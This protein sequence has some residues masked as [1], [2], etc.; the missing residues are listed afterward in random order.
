MLYRLALSMVEGLGPIGGRTLLDAYAGDLRA[1]FTDTSLPEKLKLPENIL[2]QL[3]APSLLGKAAHELEFMEKKRVKGLWFEDADYPWRLR[4]C[5]DAPLMLYV[6]GALPIESAHVLSVVGTRKMTA[7]GRS[8]TQKWVQVLAETVPDLLIV[9]GLALGVDVCA[10]RAALDAGLP[11]A[12]VLGNGLS[13]IYPP[14]HRDIAVEMVEHGALVTE[15]PHD[16][17]IEPFRF[18]QRNRIVAGLSDACLVIESAVKGG[19]MSTAR[20]ARDYNREVYAVPGRTNDPCSAGCNELI[21]RNTASILTSPEA[22]IEEMG[23]QPKASGAGSRQG[24]LFASA[25]IDSLDGPLRRLLLLFE[26]GEDFTPERLLCKSRTNPAAADGLE[27]SAAQ[28]VTADLPEPLT[29]GGNDPQPPL[30]MAG[31]SASLLQLELYG[32]VV[33]LP[34]NRWRLA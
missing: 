15:L 26:P 13:Q 31:I 18:L 25:V 32:V 21:R 3:R 30:T 7:Y 11:T 5:A 17:P 29:L 4:E 9:S 19:S 6:R 1:V 10:H 33:H 16:T 24:N 27:A 14:A 22:L 23:W 12:G 20:L 28:G 34:G 2:Q 8:V